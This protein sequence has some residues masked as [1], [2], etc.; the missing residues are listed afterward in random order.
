MVAFD[1][2]QRVLVTVNE[3]RQWEAAEIVKVDYKLQAR[4]VKDFAIDGAAKGDSVPYR[5]KL[6]ESGGLRPISDPRCIKEWTGENIVRYRVDPKRLATTSSS[7][8]SNAEYFETLFA[9]AIK[10]RNLKATQWLYKK[11]KKTDMEAQKLLNDLITFEQASMI[12]EFEDDSQEKTMVKELSQLFQWLQ[13]QYK[14][15]YND[16]KDNLNR[17]PE[18]VAALRGDLVLLSYVLKTLKPTPGLH[19]LDIFDTAPFMYASRKGHVN[20]LRMYLQAIV[21]KKQVWTGEQL[22]QKNK[23][24][25]NC[26][27]LAKNEATKDMLVSMRDAVDGKTVLLERLSPAD[28]EAKMRAFEQEVRE[29][30][31]EG[32]VEEFQATIGT[33]TRASNQNVSVNPT[34]KSVRLKLGEDL[35]ILGS[36]VSLR[37]ES[38]HEFLR[39]LVD[40][41]QVRGLDI[42]MGAFPKLDF[43]DAMQYSLENDSL[44]AFEAIQNVHPKLFSFRA[45]VQLL[46]CK[47]VEFGLLNKLA[48]P[49]ELRAGQDLMECCLL[50][51]VEPSTRDAEARTVMLRLLDRNV[52]RI[53]YDALLHTALMKIRKQDDT[54]LPIAESTVLWLTKEKGC[55]LLSAVSEPVADYYVAAPWMEELYEKEMEALILAQKTQISLKVQPMVRGFLTRS[56]IHREFVDFGTWSEVILKIDTLRAKRSFPDTFG[57]TWAELKL[58][59]NYVSQADEFDLYEDEAL[60][61]DGGEEEDL[62]D[63]EEGEGAEDDDDIIGGKPGDAVVCNILLTAEALKWLRIRK[64]E[65]YRSLFYDRIDQ[66]ARGGKSYCLSKRLKGSK[67]GALETK[68]DKGQRIIWTQRGNERMIWFICKHDKISRCCELID[69]SYSRVIK[70]NDSHLVE[71]IGN[72]EGMEEPEMLANPVANV[73]LKIHAVETDG[74]ARLLEDKNWTPPLRLT[75]NEEEIVAREGTVLL[76]GRSGTGKTLCVCNRMAKDRVVYG[77]KIRQLFVSRT[78]RL[79]EYV[80]ALQKRAGEDMASVAMRRID[81]FVDEICRDLDRDRKWPEKYRIDYDRFCEIIWKDIKGKERELDALQ[82]WTQFRTFIKGSYEAT[83]MQRPLALEEYLSLGADRCRLTD[84]QRRRAYRFF[85]SYRRVLKDKGW[86]DEVDR[87]TFTYDA[88]RTRFQEEGTVALYDRIYVDEIQDITQ[89]EITLLF[90]VTGNNYDAMFFAGDT[91]Q[92]VS[93]GVDFRFEEIRSIVHALSEGKKRLERPEKL[94]RNFRSHNGILRVSNLVLNRLHTAFPASASKLPPDTGLVLGPRP[95]LITMNYKEIAEIIKKNTRLRVLVR[96]EFKLDTL[97]ELGAGADSCIGIRDAKGLEFRDVVILD[98]FL[99]IKKDKVLQR[100]WKDLLI[101]RANEVL[102]VPVSMELELKLLYTAITRSCDRLFFIETQASQAYNAWCRRLKDDELAKQIN[103][104][105]LGERGVMTTDD[106]MIEGIDI[107]SQVSDSDFDE[108]I[109]LLGRAIGNFKKANLKSYEQKCF[110]NMKA[111]Q[112]MEE[113]GLF[114]NDGNVETRGK[115][116]E[117]VSAYLDAGMVNEAIRS[118]RR[119][120]SSNNVSNVLIKDMH[121]L[122][123]LATELNEG[124]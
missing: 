102:E 47:I 103:S 106:W 116:A 98:F 77:N 11:I 45:A 6:L 26:W 48:T 85:E 59:F 4:D 121:K 7:S 39:N 112:L 92:T 105:V 86:W 55:E 23:M 79:C 70:N 20:L 56:R 61:A 114:L 63:L 62:D 29:H 119:F 5:V 117:A 110:A 120:C 21:E 97:K 95:G 3:G 101:P 46:C 118:C 73:P 99:H 15:S 113:A 27:S 38:Y 66:L 9:L 89:A 57:K 33:A 17:T 91:A 75:S 82:I 124:D 93:Q 34:L 83:S 94:A 60:A 107:A 25:D 51:K 13:K 104:D 67:H 71:F 115:A 111:L 52:N 53:D 19:P 8:S 68:L 100:A 123:E 72:E 12:V 49:E 41:D 87:A 69:L 30:L 14:V 109:K 78:T 50:P 80:E 90:L 16:Y 54:D 28:Y 65:K 96:D 10:M 18:H 88:L 32:R 1:V 64:D 2:S 42:L 74:L 37:K 81:D 35:L 84:E 58:E 122:R 31:L 108:A 40:K 24:G 22:E 43:G 76:I 36:D 44:P